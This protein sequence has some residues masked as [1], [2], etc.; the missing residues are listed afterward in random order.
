MGHICAAVNGSV[1]IVHLVSSVIG[2]LCVCLFTVHTLFFG[3]FLPPVADQSAL[4]LVYLLGLFW[5]LAATRLAG[6]ID[7]IIKKRSNGWR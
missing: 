5:I 6:N 1:C 2:N 4:D 3:L 7:V